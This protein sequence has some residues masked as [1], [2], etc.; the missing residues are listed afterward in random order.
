MTYTCQ[1]KNEMGNRISDLKLSTGEIIES[2]KNYTI[3]GW[4]SINPEVEGPPIYKLLED[5][6][7][8][9]KIIKPKNNNPVK[10]KGI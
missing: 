3:G 6:I 9:E 7:S 8:D 1:P 4:G 10:I 5:Y 2:E